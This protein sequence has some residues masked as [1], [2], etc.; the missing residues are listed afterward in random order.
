MPLSPEQ[1]ESLK[2]MVRHAK[3]ISQL[4]DLMCDDEYAKY[5]EGVAQSTIISLN[6]ITDKELYDS[7]VDSVCNDTV[8]KILRDPVTGDRLMKGESEYTKSLI[9]MYI[10]DSTSAIRDKL[11][12]KF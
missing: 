5:I 9:T 7:I 3:D 12:A 2:S 1:T 11:N 4:I 10:T 8:G 6:D